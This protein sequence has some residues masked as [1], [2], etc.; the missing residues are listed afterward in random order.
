MAYVELKVRRDKK[1][2]TYFEYVVKPKL[3]SLKKV[4][5]L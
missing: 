2:M 5:Y 4:S 3:G 1:E